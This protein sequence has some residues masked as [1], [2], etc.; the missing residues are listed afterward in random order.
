MQLYPKI[1]VSL[2]WPDIFRRLVKEKRGGICYERDELLYQALTLIGF[3]AHRIECQ[4]IKN[5][6]LISSTHD[7]MALAVSLNKKWYL[8]DAAWKCFTYK[9]TYKFTF[10][11][12]I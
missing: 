3:D 4:T 6:Y 8:V 2:E 10:K 1:E 7:H 5:N 9:F 12:Y 11:F